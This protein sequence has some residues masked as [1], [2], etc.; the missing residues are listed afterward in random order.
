MKTLV[1]YAD[2]INPGDWRKYK[3]LV[4]DVYVVLKGYE[5]FLLILFERYSSSKKKVDK[6]KRLK[7]LIT[8][9]EMKNLFVEI[10]IKKTK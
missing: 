1:K 8:L 4:Y 7:G 6:P 9:D 3:Y 5:N 10:D 2:R